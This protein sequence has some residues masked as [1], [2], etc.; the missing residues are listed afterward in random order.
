MKVNTINAMIESR[1]RR[2]RE[3]RTELAALKARR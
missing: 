2:I 3:L 1:Q